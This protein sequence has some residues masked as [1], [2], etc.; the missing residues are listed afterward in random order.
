MYTA[1]L[2]LWEVQGYTS[3]SIFRSLHWT[4]THCGVGTNF[5]QGQRDELEG[6][7]LRLIPPPSVAERLLGG[8]GL[9]A[10]RSGNTWNHPR[11]VIIL[12]VDRPLETKDPR[13]VEVT[14]ATGSCPHDVKTSAN[15]C[16]TAY[17]PQLVNMMNSGNKLCC[18][19]DVETLRAFCES[20]KVHIG[21]LS[22][23]RSPLNI[24]TS[25]LHLYW[26]LHYMRKSTQWL[27]SARPLAP[28][29]AI[30]SVVMVCQCATFCDS[31]SNKSRCEIEAAETLQ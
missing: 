27:H 25:T 24:C 14:S 4:F 31:Y 19:M 30:L 21:P 22:I 26:L 29:A 23:C 7:E 12:R 16:F 6:E 5:K 13:V 15:E 28:V 20:L 11:D 1:V 18:G 9:E 17:S 3:L 8:K 10:G 2:N